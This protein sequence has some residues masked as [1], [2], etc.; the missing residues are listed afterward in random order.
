MLTA[1]II[2]RRLSAGL[3]LFLLVIYSYFWHKPNWNDLGRYDLIMA[4]AERG[5]LCIDAYHQNTGDKALIQGHYYSD[6]APGPALLGIPLYAGLS[7]LESL[8]GW[9]VDANGKP[10]TLG[11][12]AKLLI[13]KIILI[14]VVSAL[15]SVLLFH[16]LV[17]LGLSLK[18]GLVLTLGY[19]LGTLAFPYSTLFYGHQFACACLMTGFILLQQQEVK[20]GKKKLF[21]ALAGF[22]AGYAV[23]SEYPVILLAALLTGYLIW[24]EKSLP[25][26][27]WFILGAAIP[28]VLLLS[29]NYLMTGSL[30]KVGYFSVAGAEFRHQMDKGV[31]GVTY[32]KLSA[33]WGITF[34]V[35]RGLFLLNPFLLLALPGFYF[36][37]KQGAAIKKEWGFCLAAFS[38]F[39]LFNASYYMWWGGWSLGPRHLIPIL[40]CLIIP[41]AF[42]P[43]KWDKVLY[44]LIGISIFFMW[45]GTSVD[46][47]IPD[48]ETNPL[49][50]YALSMFLQDRVSAN[51]GVLLGLG[52]SGGDYLALLL[53]IIG[54]ALLY[55]ATSS[56]KE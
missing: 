11:W 34:S 25:S 50:G 46:P 33:L 32:P 47:Q 12:F 6:K 26:L 20:E 16:Y 40:P 49:F 56:A 19:S 18:R 4:V 31:A 13:I 41:L 27:G 23:F 37:Y 7:Q 10:T 38:V 24:K 48:S 8:L 35:Y 15:F 1:N 44:P 45:L 5:T 36:M 21:L 14:G 42:L 52:F 54:I 51:P 39:L 29:Y 3:F 30:F 22:L 43:P 17:S 2:P 53:I 55:T 9:G 28:A